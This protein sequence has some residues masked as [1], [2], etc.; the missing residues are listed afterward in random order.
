[1]FDKVQAPNHCH[2]C[3]GRGFLWREGK[4]LSH[5]DGSVRANFYSQ[6]Q[7]CNECFGTGV[8]PTVS[9]NVRRLLWQSALFVPIA[10]G[11]LWAIVN[12]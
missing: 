1:M 6:G 4:I 11:V 9:I 10:L 3:N 2:K 8:V 7:A 5:R 12:L